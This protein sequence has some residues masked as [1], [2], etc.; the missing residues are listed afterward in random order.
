MSGTWIAFK[1]QLILSN[2]REGKVDFFFSACLVTKFDLAVTLCARIFINNRHVMHSVARCTEKSV[3]IRIFEMIRIFIKKS[4]KGTEIQREYGIKKKILSN[5]LMLCTCNFI[6][7][8]FND[9]WAIFISLVQFWEFIG[10]L[11]TV[12]PDVRKS[13]Y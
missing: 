10:S 8:Y 2:T 6:V 12:L 11:S 7:P 5:G 3:L 4:A 9:N 1:I 13:P